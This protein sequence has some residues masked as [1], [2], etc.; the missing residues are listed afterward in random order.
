M[1]FLASAA[2]T[3]LS[4]LSS[5]QGIAGTF[6]AN[7][8]QPAATGTQPAG[9][10]AAFAPSAAPPTQQPGPG[11]GSST[12][13]MSAQTMNT[14]LAAQGQAGGSGGSLSEKLFSLLDTNG[15]G[16][17]SKD[18]FE[19]AFGQNGKTSQAD[20]LFAKLDQ[21]GDGGV[22]RKELS[23]AL[24]KGRHHHHAHAPGGTSPANQGGG[25]ATS[26]TTQTTTNADGST[27]PAGGTAGGG[28]FL[29]QLIQRQSQMLTASPGQTLAT[30]A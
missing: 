11:G 4:Y 20:A 5:L 22:S 3:A 25:S 15:D 6:Q 10:G 7:G 18:E 2:G 14:L 8:A 23:S 21:D 19:A 1:F 9:Q 30:S 28:S 12:W 13:P 26:P 16:T 27:T 17:I 29:E 24:R